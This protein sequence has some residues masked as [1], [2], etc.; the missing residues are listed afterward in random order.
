MY[1][2]VESWKSKRYELV[3][4][5]TRFFLFHYFVPR[6]KHFGY[7]YSS[8]NESFPSCLGESGQFIEALSKTTIQRSI[9]VEICRMFLIII[10]YG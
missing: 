10:K 6:I 3:P 1:A 9:L 2:L 4:G 7:G 5:T 8:R